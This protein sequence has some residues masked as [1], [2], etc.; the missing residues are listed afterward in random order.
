MRT[1]CPVATLCALLLTFLPANINGQRRR[2]T[3]PR[4][5]AP[6][7]PP[8]SSP[9]RVVKSYDPATDRTLVTTR[10]Y[11]LHLSSVDAAETTLTIS[12]AFIVDGREINRQPD[13]YLLLISSLSTRYKFVE[14]LDLMIL[15]D[16]RAVNF[17]RMIRRPAVNNGLAEEI[18]S[19]ITTPPTAILL[20]S[21]QRLDLEV[22]LLRNISVS[23]EFIL[24]LRELVSLAPPYDPNRP[25]AVPK[26]EKKSLPCTESSPPVVRG[27][28]LGASPQEALG[29]FAGLTLAP[30]DNIPRG[31]T[32]PNYPSRETYGQAFVTLN[33]YKFGDSEKYSVKNRTYRSDIAQG[34]YKAELNSNFFTDLVGIG[35]VELTFVDQKMAIVEIRYTDDIKW[36]SLKE[37]TAK[38]AE[39]LGLSGGWASG[40]TGYALECQGFSLETTSGYPGMTI[41]LRDTALTQVVAGRKKEAEEAEK[42]RKRDQKEGFRP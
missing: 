12:A 38:T 13:G 2:E 10:D 21:A 41:R 19:T 1:T 4:V 9:S 7:Q 36:A 15:A 23:G 40:G 14:Y 42:R 31:Y 20:S 28:K 11:K 22:G 25:P 24:A 33:L 5:E 3:R 37:F 30:Q 6:A 8:Q 35:S 32:P 18:L 17:G 26:S 16:G 27:F 39:S 29:R 34:N